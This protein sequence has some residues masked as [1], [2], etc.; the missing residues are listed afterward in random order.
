MIQSPA[1]T[2]NVSHRSCARDA[3]IQR[4]TVTGTLLLGLWPVAEPDNYGRKFSEE[5][6]QPLPHDSPGVGGWGRTVSEE[7]P[8]PLDFF[9]TTT[10]DGLS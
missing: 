1:Y 4:R 6:F 5:G 3:R 10:V 7:R 2:S 8:L 9:P